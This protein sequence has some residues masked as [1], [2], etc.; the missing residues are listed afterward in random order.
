MPVNI[1]IKTDESHGDNKTREWALRK[2]SALAATGNAAK[3][4]AEPGALATGW[5]L[6]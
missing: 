6:R 1:S 3:T 2:N 4:K 5:N